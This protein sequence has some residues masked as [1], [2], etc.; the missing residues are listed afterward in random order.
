MPQLSVNFQNDLF[1]VGMILG[2]IYLSNSI[3]YIV[4]SYKCFITAISLQIYI[5]VSR[6]LTYKDKYK[7][8]IPLPINVH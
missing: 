8:K 5:D 2:V 1:F 7:R 6:L 4:Y 3:N